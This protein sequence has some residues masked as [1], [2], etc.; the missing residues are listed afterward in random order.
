MCHPCAGVW[1]T[2]YEILFEIHFIK[3]C[4]DAVTFIN[5]LITIAQRLC[6]IVLLFFPDGW[7]QRK[8]SAESTYCHC[9]VWYDSHWWI[10]NPWKQFQMNFWNGL[11]SKTLLRKPNITTTTSLPKACVKVGL[12]V[13]KYKHALSLFI[14]LS[15]VALSIEENLLFKSGLRNWSTLTLLNVIVVYNEQCQMVWFLEDEA[16]GTS[17]EVDTGYWRHLGHEIGMRWGS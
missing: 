6:E 17:M 10:L 13:W 7:M 15:L 8:K 11:K 16:G 2:L 1:N 12:H 4:K 3:Y 14:M 9:C 5:S